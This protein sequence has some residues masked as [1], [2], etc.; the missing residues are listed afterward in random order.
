MI[1]VDTSV[2][3]DFFR[4]REPIFAQL[5]PILEKQEA[6]A[7]ECIFGELL[8]GAK[9]EDERN[10]LKTY[11]ENLPKMEEE[12]LWIEAGL[13][14]SK[15]K[16]FSKGIGLIDALIITVARKQKVKVWTL[17]KKLSA[18]LKPKEIFS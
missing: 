12:G 16:L 1:L 3:I 18:V 15:E 9:N 2:W 5:K 4:G 8:Q 7:L 13:F 6:L 10:T 11:W 17:D 14:S